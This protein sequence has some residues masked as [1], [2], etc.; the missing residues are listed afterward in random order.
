[1]PAATAARTLQA[2]TITPALGAGVKNVKKSLLFIDT[3]ETLSI[4][5]QL[6]VYQQATV[7]KKKK[8]S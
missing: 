8:I 5:K 7:S 2:M 3:F 1:M 6:C 4:Y